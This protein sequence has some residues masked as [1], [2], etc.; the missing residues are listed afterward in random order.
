ML[1]LATNFD[2]VFDP[3]VNFQEGKE[4]EPNWAYTSL[5]DKELF[6]DALAMRTTEPGNVLAYMQHWLSFQ[7]RF[8]EVLPM[9]PVYS[10]IYFDFYTSALHDYA[11]TENTTWGQ[12]I[13]GT[14][15][16]DEAPAEES[17]EGAEMPGE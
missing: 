7:E 14:T 11:I 15:L 4:G 1:F 10:N 13:L 12:A 9:I 6:A 3:S 8:N 2:I 17:T 5:E 16:G